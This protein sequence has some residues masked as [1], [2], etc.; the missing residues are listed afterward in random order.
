M[1]DTI[2]F[3]E[4]IFDKSYLFARRGAAELRFTRSERTLLRLFTENVRKVLTRDQLLDALA[5]VGSEVS[6]RNIDY[7]IN[8]L[9]AKLGIWI[10][11]L[12]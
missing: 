10:L 9:R 12:I 8:R 4:L 6:D 5:G 11:R 3:G 1:A 2:Q 7:L